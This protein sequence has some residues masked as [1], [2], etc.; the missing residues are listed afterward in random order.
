MLQERTEELLALQCWAKK[1]AQ[2]HAWW[3]LKQSLHSSMDL[4][5][6]LPHGLHVSL[7]E[8]AS[9]PTSKTDVLG[10]NKQAGCSQGM[11]RDEQ[12]KTKTGVERTTQTTTAM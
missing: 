5:L 7:G 1:A 3:Q 6:G 2:M 4:T 8:V 12:V 9:L 11:M 10:H